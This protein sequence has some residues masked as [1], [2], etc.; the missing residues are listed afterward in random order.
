MNFT[1]SVLNFFFTV[2][3]VVLI[4]WQGFRAYM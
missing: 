3:V 1:N 4:V 2:E